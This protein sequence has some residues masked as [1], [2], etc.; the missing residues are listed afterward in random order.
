MICLEPRHELGFWLGTGN[1]DPQNTKGTKVSIRETR[2]GSVVNH[3]IAVDGEVLGWGG[4]GDRGPDGLFPS[5][6]EAAQWIVE[7]L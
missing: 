5:R 4:W 6:D 7:H 2:W 3:T 1:P